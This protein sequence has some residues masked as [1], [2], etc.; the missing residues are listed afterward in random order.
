MHCAKKIGL[1]SSS[2]K[3]NGS[4]DA[5]I[6][7]LQKSCDTS[8]IMCISSTQALDVYDPNTLECTLSAANIHYDRVNCIE[9]HAYNPNIIATC[10]DDK[11]VKL[12]DLRIVSNTN[13]NNA[14]NIVST[15]SN[16][17]KGNNSGMVLG[18]NMG[19]EVMDI[20]LGGNNDNLL[21]ST[22]S[23]V[24]RF[25]D[26]RFPVVGVGSNGVYNQGGV[27]STS[28]KLGEYGDVHTDDV[29]TIMFNPHNK[30][31]LLSGS[32]DGCLC[33]YDVSVNHKEQAVSSIMNTN[34]PIR[35]IGYFD[36]EQ[37]GIYAFST[38]ESASFW[39]ASSALSI[40]WEPSLREKYNVDY[41]IDNFYLQGD[42]YIFGGTYTGNAK[43]C[44]LDKPIT[45]NMQNHHEDKEENENDDEIIIS[46]K[47]TPL[48]FNNGHTEVIRTALVLE[49]HNQK[50][51]RMLTGGEDGK[52]VL[53]DAKE[54]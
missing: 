50:I 12:W 53:W 25:H 34:C 47:D 14:S 52:I 1:N 26:V 8:K 19:I 48:I 28:L 45:I 10:S 27:S 2:G 40:K 42:N 24:I 36:P 17:S 39:H 29:N 22:Y 7:S 4:N 23:N 9:A 3:G 20:A 38:I 37:E 31:E 49:Y 6:F 18:L 46:K 54:F 51:Q 35:K 33:V 32:E 43:L 5:Y 44:L 16:I 13:A 11:W 15:S 30:W 41:L 21:A